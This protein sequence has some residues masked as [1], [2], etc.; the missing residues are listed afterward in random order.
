M[1][2]TMSLWALVLVSL[3]ARLEA[4]EFIRGDANSDG[5][6]SI[7]DAVFSFY[8]LFMGGVPPECAS[9]AD[10]NDDGHVDFSDPIVGLSALFLGAPPPPAPFPNP[11]PDPTPKL[12]CAAYGNG[13]PLDDPAAK[14][15]VV[16]T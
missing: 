3:G 12:D 6:V 7:S 11:G 15:E 16:S 4:T 14:M 8:F 10:T 2:G 5:V 13:S 9:A 1:K